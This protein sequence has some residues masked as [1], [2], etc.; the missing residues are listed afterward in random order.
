M[1][2]DAPGADWA[3][4]CYSTMAFE[5]DGQ[6]SLAAMSQWAV[7]VHPIRHRITC[8]GYVLRESDEVEETEPQAAVA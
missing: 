1:R 5:V 7:S 2:M 6:R 3:R 8:Y 4:S